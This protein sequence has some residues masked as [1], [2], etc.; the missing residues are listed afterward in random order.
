MTKRLVDIDDRLL[1]KAR[2]VAGTATAEATIGHALRLLVD[3]DTALRHVARLR[4]PGALDVEH[5]A[6]ARRPRTGSR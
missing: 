2:R 5:L 4:R 1:E 3:R 6:G